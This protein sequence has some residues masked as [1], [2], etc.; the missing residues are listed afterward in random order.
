MKVKIKAKVK[1]P[2]KRRFVRKPDPERRE[3]EGK[4]CLILRARDLS[5]VK[6]ADMWEEMSKV[7]LQSHRRDMLCR[8]EVTVELTDVS[9]QAELTTGNALRDIG[10]SSGG[11]IFE[12]CGWPLKR[13]QLHRE[14]PPPCAGARS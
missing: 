4:G 2:P 13:P 10:F 12:G 1:M 9:T 14:G 3:W 8:Q 6:D 11:G 5:L 7:T